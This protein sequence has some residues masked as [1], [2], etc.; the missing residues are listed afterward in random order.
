MRELTGSAKIRSW[1]P[2]SRTVVL[3]LTVLTSGPLQVA[4]V[5][6]SLHA[7]VEFRQ[8]NTDAD[9]AI[10]FRHDY[11]AGTPLSRLVDLSDDSAL[12]DS[13]EF[14]FHTFEK[15]DGHSPRRGEGKR[16]SILAEFDPVIAVYPPKA[17]K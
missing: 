16:L 6:L 10:G 5:S 3:R 15:R 4:G 9:F 7:F 17:L 1:H 12:H 14:Q 2:A 11:H 13:V 8:V